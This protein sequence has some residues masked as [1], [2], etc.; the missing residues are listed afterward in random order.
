MIQ[1]TGSYVG[2]SVV[3]AA[4]CRY[5]LQEGYRVAPFKA[6]NMSNNS[7]VTALGGEMG[8]AQAFQAQ[9]CGIEPQVEMNP[10]LLKPTT[11]VGAQV[12][13]LGKV[14]KVMSAR[15]YHEYQPHLL[16]IIRGALHET[17]ARARHRGHR[18]GRQP[19]RG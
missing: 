5:F 1:G 13:V 17:F 16:G 14:V 11:E 12:V 4:L 7:F 15:E 9:A 2:K 6:Q 3:T 19:R 10:I 8:R 18:R